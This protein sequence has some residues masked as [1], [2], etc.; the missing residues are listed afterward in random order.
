MAIVAAVDDDGDNSRT[1]TV[2]KDLAEKYDTRLMVLNV[3]P[4][5]L[6]K[7]RQTNIASQPSTD[8][9]YTLNDGED[10]AA[11]VAAEVA[12]AALGSLQDVETAGRV[13]GAA[14]EILKFARDV[15]AEYL[16]IGGRKQSPVGKAIFGSTT[17]SILLQADRPVT[18]VMPE[19]ED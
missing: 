13:G 7:E 8:A 12:E 6:F 4:Q 10:D 15:D 1:L 18:V 3:L 19:E 14:K 2:A 11:E 16:V 5:D 9:T 17:Q